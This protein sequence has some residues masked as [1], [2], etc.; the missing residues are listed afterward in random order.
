[1]LNIEV[2]KDIVLGIMH[3]IWETNFFTCTGYDKKHTFLKWQCTLIIT[4]LESAKN[5]VYEYHFFFKSATQFSIVNSV[6]LT[7]IRIK[8]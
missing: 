2:I 6:L 4:F 8:L 1:M 7:L 3:I 5:S